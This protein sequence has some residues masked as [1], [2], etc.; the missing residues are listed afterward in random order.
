MLIQIHLTVL[1]YNRSFFRKKKY[2]EGVKGLFALYKE[3]Q[4]NIEGVNGLDN[5]GCPCRELL[6]S[7][8]SRHQDHNAN[9]YFANTHQY[10][11]HY[12]LSRSMDKSIFLNEVKVKNEWNFLVELAKINS[13]VVRFMDQNEIIEVSKWWRDL[14]IANELM[15]VG[16][17]PL[18]WY[19][20]PWHNW[21]SKI[22][23][24][25]L[26][27]Y[28]NARSY[29][30]TCGIGSRGTARRTI[31]WDTRSGDCYFLHTKG[32]LHFK[33]WD[34]G[35]CSV[36]YWKGPLALEN[37]W[38]DDVDFV[39][40]FPD[41]NLEDKVVLDERSN[42]TPPSS[43]V[44]SLID[45]GLSPPFESNGSQYKRGRNLLARWL[46]ALDESPMQHLL[47]SRRSSILLGP[48]FPKR[49]DATLG[50]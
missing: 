42:D 30:L 38:E 9:T 19:M 50:S 1:K 35:G 20:W 21:H 24:P 10:P 40:V 31:Y 3:S 2:D 46:N 6:H 12:G 13:S 36:V 34:P 22:V 27:W 32:Y 44:V 48:Y 8:L 25:A 7:W 5:A 17:Q 33:Q 37:T 26:S 41:F 45:N 4:L 18:K 47:A 49:Y 29:T 23:G 11:F 43:D 14:G 16:Y 28:L 15:F 39:E